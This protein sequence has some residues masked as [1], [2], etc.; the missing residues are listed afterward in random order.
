MDI[1]NAVNRARWESWRAEQK[2]EREKTYF[3]C[4]NDWSDVCEDTA[5]GACKYIKIEATLDGGQLK[6]HWYAACCTP[7][8]ECGT[9]WGYTQHVTIKV[10][11][12]GQWQE[13]THTF[14]G[15]TGSG[16]D[17][18]NVGEGPHSCYGIVECHCFAFIGTTSA[19][20]T[21]G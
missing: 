18:F 19:S 20:C 13:K 6:V 12:G 11:T 14:G 8:A 16:D 2:T 5:A 21:V 17:Y 1:E 9:A 15:A 4:W 10:K 7:I 3:Y